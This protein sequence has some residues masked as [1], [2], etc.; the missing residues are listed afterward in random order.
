MVYNHGDK[1]YGNC[2]EKMELCKV[3]EM[4]SGEWLKTANWNFV[5]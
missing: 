2:S 1:E 3:E 5:K 4:A